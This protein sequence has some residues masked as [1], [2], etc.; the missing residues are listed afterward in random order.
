MKSNFAPFDLKNEIQFI[1]V[2]INYKNE[3]VNLEYTKDI[4][5]CHLQ[6]CV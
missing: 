4:L 3:T 2:K 5:P 6:R 1:P